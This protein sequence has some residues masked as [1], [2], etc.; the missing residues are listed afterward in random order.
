MRDI[1]PINH[2]ILV[3]ALS[4]EYSI[5]FSGYLDKKSYL[6]VAEDGMHMRNHDFNETT[7]LVCSDLF[8]LLSFMFEREFLC[9]YFVLMPPLL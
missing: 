7:K 8:S 3:V 4:E 9:H 6:R 5:L 1:Y 2:R